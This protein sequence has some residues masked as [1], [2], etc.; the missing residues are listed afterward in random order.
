MGLE[1]KEQEQGGEDEERVPLR[2]DARTTFRGH[3]G[4][5]RHDHVCLCIVHLPN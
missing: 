1:E 5:C 3:S 4:L 2:N